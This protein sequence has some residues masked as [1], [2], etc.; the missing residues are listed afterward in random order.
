MKSVSQLSPTSHCL[1]LHEAA[2]SP[3]ASRRSTA[4]TNM[5]SQESEANS[6]QVNP[7]IRRTIA[8][9][10]LAFTSKN[11]WQTD[12]FC[13]YYHFS[14]RNSGETKAILLPA[15]FHRSESRRLKAI[16]EHC[17]VEED[18]SCNVASSYDISD[19][20]QKSWQCLRFS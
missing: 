11:E 12:I 2:E 7:I 16:L 14:K 10:R 15:L 9:A 4:N 18:R 5:T 8:C 19:I 6:F 3:M 1:E 17:F 13:I 20:T